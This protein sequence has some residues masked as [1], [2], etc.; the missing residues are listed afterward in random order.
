VEIRE[1]DKEGGIVKQIELQFMQ[2]IWPRPFELE[3]AAT[4]LIHL[5]S[6]DRR[7]QLVF[8]ARAKN[9]RVHY[10]IGADK[11]FMRRLIPL[12][13]T[14][15]Q[16]ARFREC[17]N[18]ASI[19]LVRKVKLSHPSLALNTKNTLAVIR[20]ALASLSQTKKSGDETVVSIILG[21]QYTPS[22]L[23]S[24]LQ[25]PKASWLD[26]IMGSVAQATSESR[27]SLQ[28][29]ASHHG[30]DA[31]IYIGAKSN[32]EGRA[33]ENMRTLFSGLK[34]AEAVGVKM[35]AALACS[36]T[37][38]NAKFPWGFPFSLRLS[39]KELLTLLCWPLGDAELAGV[40]GLHPKILMP[41][42]WYK[43]ES[44]TFGTCVDG[45]VELGISPK[46]SLSHS[47]LLGPT[48]AGKST[49]MLN[50]IMDDI[51]SGDRSVC[52][53][54][55]KS[56]LITDILARIPKSREKDV[57]VLDPSSTAMPVGFNPLENSG[58]NPTLTA[59][60]ILAVMQQ[61]FSTSFG[62]RT[63]DILSASLLTLASIKGTT[64]VMLPAL[65]TDSTFRRKMVQNVSDPFLH[66]FW[67]EFEAMTPGSR[68]Q[69][70]A[71][72]LNKI[73]RLIL[74]PEMRAI[75]GQS[76]PKASLKDMF[77]GR[78]IFLIPLNR[79]LIGTEC[80]KLLGSLVVGQLWALTLARADVS[81]EKRHIINVWIDEAPA[82]ISSI[83]S[84]LSEA[85]AMARGLGVSIN[86]ALQYLSQVSPEMKAAF[87]TNIRSKVVFGLGAADAVEVAKNA[88]ELI[89][90]DFLKLPRFHAYTHLLQNGKSTG[91]ISSKTFPATPPTRPAHEVK[92]ISMA[93]H[94]RDVKEVEREYLGILGLAE[95]S[96]YA[97]GVPNSTIKNEQVGRK[98]RTETENE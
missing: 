44:R 43:S 81:P 66:G 60:S 2:V 98:R 74:R 15:I 6:M 75:L 67:A 58:K 41:P 77:Y 26:S 9:G 73:R 96:V 45:R 87:E 80:A 14:E 53:L 83:S 28:E 85:L 51:N 69:A 93:A 3:D 70:V 46:D 57:V 10:L 11:S 42:N 95:N 38:D 32:S 7:G 56:G 48:G 18:R 39:V 84:D 40:A 12:V 55:P 47:M 62:V 17:K 37:I 31:A 5:A 90:E 64:L 59:D 91:W 21:K 34:T 71:P 52:V 78:K 16:G 89:A 1:T 24:K 94:G 54:D 61:L 76:H 25:D 88:P 19:P 23:P 36:T 27:A 4:L 35:H 63:V 13:S 49:A 92:A 72:V 86:V 97:D 8:E 22:L 68:A 65:L 30:F 29:R 82:F 20:A 33:V 50:L 79:S